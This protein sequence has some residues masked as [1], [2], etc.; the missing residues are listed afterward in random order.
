MYFRERRQLL[1][2][3]VAVTVVV[4]AASIDSVLPVGQALHLCLLCVS[5]QN[6]TNSPKRGLE[7][8]VLPRLA[9]LQ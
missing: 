4:K 2:L 9:S 7:S 6:S 1:A 8:S 3:V 5:L